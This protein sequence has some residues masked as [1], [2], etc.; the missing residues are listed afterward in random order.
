M[1]SQ[2]LLQLLDEALRTGDLARRDV[3]RLACSTFYD[4]EAVRL[5]LVR[6]LT[7]TGVL[8]ALGRDPASVSRCP[9]SEKDLRDADQRNEIA[10]VVPGR[11]RREH[12][13]RALDLKHWIFFEPG[14]VSDGARD[15]TWMLVS[16]G[17]DLFAEGASCRA[18]TAAAEEAGV[19]PLSFEEYV[20]F[21]YRLRHLTG[22]FPDR[23]QWSWLPRSVYASSLV[24]CGGFPG[25][26]LFVNVWPWDEFHSN[27]GLRAARRGRV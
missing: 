5:D 22:Q 19:T 23:E 16:A 11:L 27:V 20:L 21:A 14:V 4:P 25:D 8:G 2:V 6:W 3:L 1:L 9:F 15:D 7:E 26:E 24:V 12:L 17:N 13:A 18:A 10:L